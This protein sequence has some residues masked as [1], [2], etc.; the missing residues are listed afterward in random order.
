MAVSGLGRI[1][2]P[3]VAEPL[4]RAA[5]DRDEQVRWLAARFLNL[6]EKPSAS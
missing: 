1:G 5:Q 6:Q 4:E 3:A 2:S